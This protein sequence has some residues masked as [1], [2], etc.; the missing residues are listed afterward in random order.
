MS[1]N[2]KQTINKLYGLQKFGIKLGL[3][4][5]QNLLQRLGN[6][7]NDLKI[8]HL[9]GS[10]GKGSVGAHILSV[11]REAGYRV[12]FYTSPHLVSFRERFRINNDLITKKDVVR[13]ADT[14]WD[15]CDHREPPTFFEFVTAMAFLYFKERQVDLAVME[16]GLGGRLDATN[17][18]Q[19]V[20]GVI[21]NISLEHTEYLGPT[22]AHVAREKAGIIKPGMAVVTGE[23][24]KNILEIFKAACRRNRAKLFILG[25]DFKVR[26]TRENHFNYDGPRTG[27][28]NLETKLV[29]PHQASNAAL[30][31]TVVNLLAE[32]GL[33]VT[34]S[35]VRQGL[36][37]VDWPGRAEKI[38]GGPGKPDLLLDGA[39]NPGAARVLAKALASHTYR[40]LHMV[41]GIMADKDMNGIMKPLIPLADRLYLTRPVY[42]RAAAPEV[43]A[44]LARGYNGPVEVIQKLPQAI[45]KARADAGPDDLVVVTGSL[46]TVGEA[47]E[48]L[49]GNID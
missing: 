21:T 14:V 49:L 10:N 2:Y 41:L 17:V 16:T 39:H 42:E 5:T 44:D 3:S 33:I 9:A 19:P 26:R 28:K 18:A 45:E 32:H 48:Y 37:T 38:P 31:I 4:S 12:G 20:V 15:V 43:L 23:K 13:L 35:D 34:E 1:M 25:R 7:Q 40:R 36:K 46:F 27:L 11:L 47:R 22:L 8:V 29:G 24:R 30:A 6:P